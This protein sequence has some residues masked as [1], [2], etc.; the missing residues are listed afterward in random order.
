[1][2]RNNQ[3]FVASKNFFFLAMDTYRQKYNSNN[4][5]VL[6][7]MAGDDG[8][9]AQGTFGNLSDIIFTTSAPE[10][11]QNLQPSFDLATMSICN[12]SIFRYFLTS[13]LIFSWFSLI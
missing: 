9:W 7:I 3:G 11:C 6:F 8:E 4:Q 1:M 13:D 5:S 2:S 10:E 12:H